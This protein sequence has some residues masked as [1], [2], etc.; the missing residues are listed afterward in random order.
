MVNRRYFN[1]FLSIKR[2]MVR[3]VKRRILDT[4]DHLDHATIGLNA[5]K[6][7]RVYIIQRRSKSMVSLSRGSLSRSRAKGKPV[8]VAKP[9]N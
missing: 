7:V 6:E 1:L 3:N 2:G 5:K 9:T 8:K 4:L